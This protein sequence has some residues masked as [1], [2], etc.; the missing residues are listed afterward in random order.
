M[1]PLTIWLKYP[2]KWMAACFFCLSFVGVEAQQLTTLSLQQAYTAAEIHFPMLKQK[3]LSLE[4]EALMIKNISTSLYPQLSFNAQATYQSDVTKVNIPLPGIKVPSQPKDQYKIIAD[5]NQVIYDGGQ[6]NVQKNL[7]QLSRAVEESRVDLDI[8][9]MKNRV[10]QLYLSILFQDALIK[11]TALLINDI[12]IGIDKVRPQVEAAVLLRSNLQVLEVQLLQNRQRSIEIQSLRR[13]MTE[14]LAVLTN[15]PLGDST[16][17]TLPAHLIN[18]DTI[19][20]RPEIKLFQ[21]QSKL[22]EG[23]VKLIDSRNRPRA[24]FFVQGGYGRPALNL[25]SDSFEP[26]YITG[27]RLNW[28]MSSLYNKRR[29][30]KLVEVNNQSIELQK[31]TFIMNTKAQLKQLDAEIRKYTALIQ[32][33]QE[34]IELR[35]RITESSRAQLENRVIT[36]NDYLREIN[37]ADMARQS[38]LTHQLQLLQAE[39]NYRIT[40][41]RF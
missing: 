34:I 26:Y 29:E 36:S 5:L 23:Q 2:V 14:A 24:S 32:T 11:Q 17:F 8:Y 28:S 40:S 1:H 35:N 31:E 10:C 27:L 39:I 38:L 20:A 9:Q 37:A 21:Q 25:L 7:Q 33:D 16:R 6:V 13:G 18:R 30:K 22:N 3:Q 19:I 41:G 12:Q 4:T 15:L